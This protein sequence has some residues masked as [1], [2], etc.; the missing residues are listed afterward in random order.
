MTFWRRMNDGTHTR[1]ALRLLFTIF[2]T[3][4]MWFYIDVTGHLQPFKYVVF[5]RR[6]HWSL[7]TA[8]RRWSAIQRYI[9]ALTICEC[10]RKDYVFTLFHTRAQLFTSWITFKV[11]GYFCFICIRNINKIGIILC[12]IWFS[13]CF[14]IN[15][16]KCNIRNYYYLFINFIIEC[17]HMVA[18]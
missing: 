13:L 17:V 5:S 18:E 8:C 6:S 15:K 16:C 3:W 2:T 4:H 14:K 7:N 12:V 9:Y 1:W 10:L 11:T